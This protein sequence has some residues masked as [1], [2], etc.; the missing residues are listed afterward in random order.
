MSAGRLR[1]PRVVLGTLQAGGG[2][3]SDR[4]SQPLGG[5][6]RPA[7]PRLLLVHARGAG[8]E[9]HHRTAGRQSRSSNLREAPAADAAYGVHMITNVSLVA[10]YCLDQEVARDFYGDVLGFQPPADAT[11]G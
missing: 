5:A 8:P 7:R 10:V 4:V 3:R 1:Q 2:R 9:R 11:P 6:E